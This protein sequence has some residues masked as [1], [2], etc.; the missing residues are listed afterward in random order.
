MVET[1]LG[2]IILKIAHQGCE[3]LCII[4]THRRLK[5][6]AIIVGGM[7]FIKANTRRGYTYY[8]VVESIWED[9]TSQQ[10]QLLYL[11]RL[12]N[13]SPAQRRK[14]QSKLA[15][16]D[17]SLLSDFYEAL[18]KHGY[19][20]TDD[21][22][23]RHSSEMTDRRGEK[24]YYLEHVEKK[25]LKSKLNETVDRPTQRLI[26]AISYKEGLSIE[27]IASCCGITTDT[28]YRWL[29]WFESE[30]SLD[31]AIHDDQGGSGRKPALAKEKRPE[32][33][34]ILLEGPEEYGF[35]GQMWTG[36]RVSEVIETEFDVSVN[37]VTAWRY[38]K[39]LGWSH[40]KPKHHSV[41]RDEVEI[42][43]FRNKDW[44]EI[45]N[46]AK[47]QSRAIVFI[48]ETKFRLLP[49]FQ[50]TWAPKGETPVVE[51]SGLF[52]PIAVIGALIYIPT[53]QKFDIQWRTQQY[54][55]D[56]QSILSFL[57]HVTEDLPQNS[58]F[59]LDNLS[60]HKAATE[61]LE[62]EATQVTIEW[63]PEYAN[64]I[65]PVDRAWGHAKQVELPNYAAKSLDELENK[66]EEALT[67]IQSDEE[68][69]RSFIEF[70]ELELDLPEE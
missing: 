55:F 63:F 45:R 5:T 14:H 4:H 37:S 12:D 24:K 10:N 19:N 66:V 9:G 17:P 29:G 16:L 50:K 52:E 54:N 40:Q 1:V 42:K 38:M 18:A 48:D 46:N 51:T 31:E 70:A 39:Q 35:T 7:A 23:F 56:A 26:A 33:E 43:K 67:T 62:D 59:I 3:I 41:K 44:I 69:L 57:R 34:E 15:E 13:L 25:S 21:D 30:E 6:I 64:G 20:F 28:I 32:L 58:T 8:N 11:G 36:P 60:A 49:T 68:L 27:T 2:F 61:Q 65:N 53:I 47:E 22:D